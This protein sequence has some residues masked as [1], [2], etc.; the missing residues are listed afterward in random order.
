VL[1]LVSLTRKTS[2]IFALS[3]VPKLYRESGIAKHSAIPTYEVVL[4]ALFAPI[5]GYSVPSLF[6]D[7]FPVLDA[8]QNGAAH[9]MA[10]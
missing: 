5:P 6:L 2:E 1:L 3:V 8:V 10:T 4:W 7:L 9:L